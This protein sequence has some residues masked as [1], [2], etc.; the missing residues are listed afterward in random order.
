M[1]ERNSDPESLDDAALATLIASMARND[2]L[3]VYFWT[4]DCDCVETDG[5]SEIPATLSAYKEHS[6]SIYANA[7][8]P[9]RIVIISHA[10]AQEFSPSRRDRITEAWENG[11]SYNV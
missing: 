3:Y 1:N 2:R 11:Q 10:E 4:R 7:E 5:V 9:T 8:G 6:D